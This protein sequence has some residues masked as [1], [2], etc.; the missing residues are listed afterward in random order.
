MRP[1]LSTLAAGCAVRLASAAVTHANPPG[2]GSMH[3]QI[4]S[5]EFNGTNA[6]GLNATK[7]GLGPAPVGRHAPQRRLREHHCRG[8]FLHRRHGQSRP[9][10]AARQFPRDGRD[11]ATDCYIDQPIYG[12]TPNTDYIFT[13]WGNVG[14][15]YWPY[16]RLG[17][18]NYGGAE[19]N[20]D[21]SS[22]GFTQATLPFTTSETS[23]TAN[24]FAYMPTLYGDTVVD[25]FNV[26]PA[27]AITD[28]G[29]ESAD[30]F[31]YW[32]GNGATYGPQSVASNNARSGCCCLAF[33]GAAHAWAGAGQDLAGLKPNTTYQLS[34][35]LK[36]NGQGTVIGVKNHNSATAEVQATNT[37]GTT[38]TRSALSFTTGATNTTATS[39]SDSDAASAGMRQRFYKIQVGP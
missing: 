23:T 24:V 26:R 2:A 9:R 39:T 5:D 3:T 15:A 4:W 19:V 14:S 34:A 6:A 35:W 8:Q 11:N 38:C 36:T 30:T 17:V 22:Y 25:D 20:Q 18:E 21:I 1:R 32:T 16:V 7:W 29:F 28:R 33:H 13:G 31:Y 12:L 10:R 27:A 37:S